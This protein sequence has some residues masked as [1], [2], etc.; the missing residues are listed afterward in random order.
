MYYQLEWKT[1]EKKNCQQN[2]LSISC[3]S[4]FHTGSENVNVIW[5][6]QNL[7]NILLLKV[8]DTFTN[9]LPAP[10]TFWSS[11]PWDTVPASPGAHSVVGKG[12][13]VNHEDQVRSKGGRGGCN[14]Q[15]PHERLVLGASILYFHLSSPQ[16]RYCSS[17]PDS[18]V[19]HLSYPRS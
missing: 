13:R 11:R 16:S 1:E 7:P 15:R 18:Q 4:A 12:R 9:L 5:K 17:N 2:K 10:S 3:V 8:W 6:V 19:G 14:Q